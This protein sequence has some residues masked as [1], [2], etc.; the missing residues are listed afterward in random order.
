M[1]DYIVDYAIDFYTTDTMLDQYP[2]LRDPAILRFLVLS[3][4]AIAWLLFGLEDDHRGQA[5][6]LKASILPQHAAFWQPILRFIRNPFIVNFAGI[7]GAQ[8][9]NAPSRIHNQHILD[10]MVFLLATVVDFLLLRIFWSC[11]RSF[12]SVV[13]EKRGAS[14]SSSTISSRSR[15]ASSAALRAGNSRWAAKAWFKISRSSRTHLLT[16]D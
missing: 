15:T 14:G 16:F 6:T 10:S 2:E 3:Q 12:C 4:R 7:R 13:T 1:T 8:K 11:Y 9:P 5:E